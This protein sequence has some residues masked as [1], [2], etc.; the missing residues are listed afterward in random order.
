MIHWNFKTIK[1]IEEDRDHLS[2]E[3]RME[4]DQRK[5]EKS[6]PVLL[7]EALQLVRRQY[8]QLKEAEGLHPT[9]VVI[10]TGDFL[11]GMYGDDKQNAL[12]VLD[13]W[14]LKDSKSL[15]AVAN[16]VAVA[17]IFEGR[18][19]ILDYKQ[20]GEKYKKYAR[21]FGHEKNLS[22]GALWYRRFIA[23]LTRDYDHTL[24]PLKTGTFGNSYANWSNVIGN[25]RHQL[26]QDERDAQNI[27]N[28]YLQ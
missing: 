14:E 8:D 13:S 26:D 21:Q 10:Y 3:E 27:N 4:Y 20:G 15:Q 28:D 19:L 9:N 18:Q 1:A 5:A 6:L 12:S 17:L 24:L 2:P 11:A 23:W 7:D 22:F 25:I 16:E